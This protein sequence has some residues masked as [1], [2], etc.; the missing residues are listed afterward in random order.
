MLPS[1]IILTSAGFRTPKLQKDLL[2]ILP[3]PPKELKVAHIVTA[4]KVSKNTDFVDRERKALKDLGFQ[5]TEM[6]IEGKNPKILRSAFKNK[7][8]IYVQGGNTFYL[9]KQVR[10]SGFGKVVKDLIN[11][12]AIYIGVSAGSYLACPTIEMA[13][14]KRQDKRRFGLRN[15]EALNL[16]PFLLSAHYNREKHREGVKEGMAKSRFPVKI[17]A[18]DQALVVANGKVKLIGSATVVKV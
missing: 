12:G 10:K 3:K 17:L 9:L 6:D 16:V 11:K 4:S 14:W 7:D 13:T 1:M 18:D 2:E 15:L 5:V 8:I